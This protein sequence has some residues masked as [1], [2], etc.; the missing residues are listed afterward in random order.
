[1][2]AIIINWLC[3]S[4]TSLS[5]IDTMLFSCLGIRT[6]FLRAHENYVHGRRYAGAHAYAECVHGFPALLDT[7]QR[8]GVLL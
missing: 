4:N 6:T 3:F 1:M 2:P 5:K 7:I 8:S